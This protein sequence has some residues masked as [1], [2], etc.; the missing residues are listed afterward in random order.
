MLN[1]FCFGMAFAGFSSVIGAFLNSS[2]M[3]TLNSI[4]YIVGI[5]LFGAI[6][7]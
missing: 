4:F 1:F 2:S 6:F 3:L 5:V 7:A